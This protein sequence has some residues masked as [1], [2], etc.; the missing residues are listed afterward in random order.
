MAPLATFPLFGRL[1]V[2]IRRLIWREY[3][4]SYDADDEPAMYLYSKNLFLRHLDPE[5]EDERYAGISHTPSVA[6]RPPPSLRVGSE[7]RNATLQW[8]RARALEQGGSARRRVLARAFDPAR[9]VVYVSRDKWDEF[10][11]LSFEGD[12][13]EET[14]AQIRHLAFPAFTAYYSFAELGHLM[15]W[16]TSL[17][18]LSSVWGPLPEL[19]YAR[20]RRF[21]PARRQ[22]QQQQQQQQRL[23]GTTDD[24]GTDTGVDPATGEREERVAAEVQPRWVLE[25]ETADMVRMCVRDPLTG[26]DMWEVG[27]RDM[28]MGELEEAMLTLELPEH[29][30]DV[31]EEKFLVEFR[32][33]RARKVGG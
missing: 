19:E 5:R 29:V 6:V 13:L 17:K 31:E 12:G 25:A 33:V 22:Q 2:E 1:P 4:S 11:E 18:T 16:F 20:T 26:S 3:L 23:L 30:Y 7:A 9:D 8:Y 14:T 21:V 28:W 27:E 24:D 15:E 32:A 10:C